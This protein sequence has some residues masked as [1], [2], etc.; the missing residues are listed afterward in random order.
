MTRKV[1]I[2]NVLTALGLITAAGIVSATASPGLGGAAT[3]DTS[4]DGLPQE[5]VL[6][7]IVRDF[8]EQSVDGGHTDF[9]Q[10]PAS[11]FGHYMGNIE[12]RL[13]ADGKPVFK[14]GGFKVSGQWRDAEGNNIHPSLYDPS[15]GDTAGSFHSTPDDGGI[16]SAAS[17]R[18]W[19]R[20]VPGVNASRELS[21]TLVRDPGSNLYVF[22][23]RN[24][25]LYRNNAKRGF[26]PINE[27]L[28]GNSSGESV[29]FHFTYELATEF[30]YKPGQGQTFTFIGDDDVFVF[31]NGKLVIDIGGV[32]SA[33]K[34]TVHLD[35]LE[36]LRPNELNSL[37]FFFAER[38]R[39]QS[40]FRIETTLN[41]R[42][43]ELPNTSNLYD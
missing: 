23:D 25:P 17:F 41:L 8:R 37:N 1:V 26:F 34:Q 40:N 30:I 21:I 10:R 20:N 9:E 43:A 2:R 19:F 39:S 18:Q 29:N 35:R 28:F 3:E 16:E 6:T 42:S 14:G 38:H 31:I 15:K 36:N 22:D 5:I 7:G 24:D 11:G 13:D 4:A 33:V 27:D 32:H 12:S